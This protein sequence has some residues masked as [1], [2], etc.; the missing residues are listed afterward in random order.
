MGITNITCVINFIHFD[1]A[2][3]ISFIGV[4]FCLHE[5]RMEREV[6]DRLGGR[7]GRNVTREGCYTPYYFFK[8]IFK[9]L[10]LMLCYC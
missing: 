4:T 5:G 2:D 9:S 7:P 8:K 10:Q 6:A 1:P 3:V